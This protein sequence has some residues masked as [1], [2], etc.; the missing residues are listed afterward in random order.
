VVELVLLEVVRGALA[1]GH[2]LEEFQLL[3]AVEEAMQVTEET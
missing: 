1:A 2:L 3:V